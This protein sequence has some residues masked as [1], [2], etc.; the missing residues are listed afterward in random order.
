MGTPPASATSR[1]CHGQQP[2]AD[3][4]WNNGQEL[5]GHTKAVTVNR[6]TEQI[7]YSQPAVSAL[8]LRLSRVATIII[9]IIPL[10]LCT[11]CVFLCHHAPHFNKNRN[12]DFWFLTCEGTWIL[13]GYSDLLLP[14]SLEKVRSPKLSIEVLSHIITGGIN[15]F[16][17]RKAVGLV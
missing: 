6:L 13:S 15:V 5:R 12:G 1:D 7:N 9:L 10:L 4:R 8:V 17:N 3:Y 16:L 14:L 11:I 2:C